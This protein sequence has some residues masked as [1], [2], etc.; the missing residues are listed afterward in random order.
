MLDFNAFFAI[1]SIS[2]QFRQGEF[3]NQ[4]F[5]LIEL[6]VVVL[7]IG[8]LSAVALPQYTTAV[9]RSRAAEALT[10]LS[11]AQGGFER[12]RMQKDKWPAG[13][14]KIDVEIPFKSDGVTRGGKN[15]ALTIS[16]CT[17]S[18]NTCSLVATRSTGN[19]YKITVT[20]TDNNNG[21]ITS[22]RK[23]EPASSGDDKA[24]TFCNAI[25]GGSNSN[26]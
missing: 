15:F 1:L 26:F 11:A 12:Y 8:I 18:A 16:D 21:T 3:M 7:I 14:A 25:T 20:M 24:T 23:C 10:L 5:T 17:E 4:G 9:E 2:G 22:V 6:L 19:V 13:F